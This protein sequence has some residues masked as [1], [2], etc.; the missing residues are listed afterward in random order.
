VVPLVTAPAEALEESSKEAESVPKGTFLDLLLTAPDISLKFCNSDSK[1]TRRDIAL[2][3]A[4]GF[5]TAVKRTE[6]ATTL[7]ISLRTLKIDD[8]LL[9]WGPDFGWLADSTIANLESQS[10]WRGPSD[11]A[12]NL[13]VFHLEMLDHAH[14]NYAAHGTDKFCEL[15]FNSLSL[16]FN[17]DTWAEFIRFLPNFAGGAEPDQPPPLT[18]K[19]TTTDSTASFGRTSRPGSSR[20]AGTD[21]PTPPDSTRI[22]EPSDDS[23]RFKMSISINAIQLSLNDQA[24]CLSVWA[25]SDSFAEVTTRS[26]GLSVEG[27]LGAFKVRDLSSTARYSHVLA[28]RGNRTLRP[29]VWE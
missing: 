28:I 21:A 18:A 19:S 20:R 12:S 26:S 2:V 16:N 13:I 24:R 14:P 11:D 17:R 22:A 4:H 1:G 15:K 23:L 9:D 3:S 5:S 8:L 7:D 10:I 25:L 29:F 27:H 6:T